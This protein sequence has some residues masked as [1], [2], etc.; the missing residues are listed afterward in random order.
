MWVDVV[1][2]LRVGEGVGGC[3]VETEDGCVGGCSVETEAG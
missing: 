3:S 2:R 1:W